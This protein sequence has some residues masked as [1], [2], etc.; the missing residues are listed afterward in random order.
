MQFSSTFN[1]YIR[2]SVCW[3]T[4]WPCPCAQ[5][6]IYKDM[7]WLVMC[8]G[9][10]VACTELCPQPGPGQGVGRRGGCPGHSVYCRDG[11]ATSSFYYKPDRSNDSGITTSVSW[12]LEVARRGESQEEM[13][14]VLS[15]PQKLTHNEEGGGA[16]WHLCPGHWLILSWC[17]LQ[18]YW[19]PF[20]GIGTLMGSQV[21]SSNISA[22]PHKCS[23]DGC[24][25]P[26]IPKSCWKP[27]E[28]VK[29]LIAEGWG[30][31]PYYLYVV[32]GQAHIG[33]MV[34]SFSKLLAK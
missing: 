13:Q 5:I 6:H 7:V 15:P 20:G 11:G 26:H 24:N 3:Y 10:E 8:G 1:E 21:F 30:G 33:R 25:F 31:T 19:T 23:I 4:I 2:V 9:T 34:R 16:I 32:L 12:T 27:F 29:T 18:R 28:W 22:R 14:A 17:C